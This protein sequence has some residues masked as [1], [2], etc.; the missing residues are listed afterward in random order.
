MQSQLKILRE[1]IQPKAM[2]PDTTPSLRDA[3]SKPQRTIDSYYITPSLRTL[4]KE[5]LDAAIHRKGQGYWYRAA[6]GDGKTHFIASM[7][8]LLTEKA[9][10]VWNALHDDELR[11]DYQAPLSGLK[12]FPVTFSLLGTGEADA[13]DSLMRRFEKEIRDSLPPELRDQVSVLSEELA[14]EW[15]ENEAGDLIKKAIADHFT[16]THGMPPDEFRAKEGARK[17]GAE[18][19]SVAKDQGVIIDV[20]GAFRERFAH[21]YDRITKLGGYDGLLFVVDEFRSWQ[22]RHEGKPSYEEGVQVLE[23]LAYYLPVEE[24]LNII[25]VI[26]S[27]G[28][29]PQKLM[30]AS[31]GDRFIVRELLSGK[32]QTD[33]G[34]IVCFRVRDVL[35]GREIEIEEYYKHC[36]DKF[37]F[38]RQTPKDYFRAIFAF[39]PRCFDILRRVTQSYDRYG[40]PSTRSGIHIA[41]E[42]LTSDSLLDGRRLVVL[43]DLLGSRTLETGLRAE[44]F[45]ASFQSYRDTLETLETLPMEDEERD[46]SRR[47]IGTL[48]LWS[49]VNADIAKGLTLNELAE[50]T[51][52]SL[53]GVTPADAVLDLV[54]RLKS[55]IPQVKYDRDKGARFEVAESTG[56]KPE[57]AFGTFKKK[58]KGNRD[59]QDRAWRDS[60][61]WDFKSLEG[62]GSE[63]G[64]DGGFFDGYGT[65]DAKGELSLPNTTVVQATPDALKVQ[66]GGDVVVTDR[67]QATL[68]ESWSNRPETHFRIVYLTSSA[69]IDRSDL[70]DP[71]SAVCS[72]AALSDETRENLAEF[73]ACEAM[74]EHYNDKDYPGEGSLR[75]WA[76]TRR[77]G[78]RVAILKNQIEEFRRGTITTQKELGLPANQFFMTPQKSRGRREEAIASQLLEKAYDRPRF[79]P[80]D[81]KKDFTDADSKKV[82]HGLFAKTPTNADQNARDNFAPGLGLVAKN[83][84]AEFAPQPDSAV[85]YIAER[86]RSASDL[87][88]SELVKELCMP[89]YGMTEDMVRLMALCAVRS[90][91]P[92][93]V[94]ADLNP[95]G[96]FKLTDGREPPNKRL[97]SRLISQTEWSTK[98]EKAFLGA[99]LKLSDEKPFNDVL[100]YALVVDPSLTTANTPDE[101]IARNSEL[102]LALNTLAGD[103]PNTRDTLKKLSGVLGGSL[104]AQTTEVFQRLA[105]IAATG[106]YQEFH[107]V[108][109]ENYTTP[110][111]FQAATDLYQRAKR[112]NARYPDLQSAKT[113]LENLA[114]LG[115]VNLEHD[116]RSLSD[117]MGFESLW[118]NEQLLKVCIEQFGRFKDKYSLAYRKGHRA[119]HEVLEKLHATLAGLDDKL[120][121]LDRLNSLELG[122]PMGQRLC[123]DV[124]NL[125]DRVRPC[126]LKDTCRVDD[127]PKCNVCHWDGQTLP[128]QADADDLVRRVNDANAEL[129]K[130]VAQGAIRKILENANQEGVRTLLDMITASRIEDLAKVLTPEMVAKLKEILAAANIEHRDLPLIPLLEDFTALEEE[131]MD[132]FL[133]RL[134][135]RLL[136]AFDKA[137][138]ETEGRKRIRFFLK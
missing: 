111:Q 101:E 7:T 133:K 73:V 119:Y 110:E 59:A 118:K 60:L 75:D 120:A 84:L 56:K 21:I 105:T 138:Q 39:Q 113:Y 64:F 14:V 41:W 90:A 32:D 10:E 106:D 76:K 50:G 91:N 85:M 4:L 108:V 27:Q 34:Q 9:P 55:D 78:A 107:S 126:A 81:L 117:G 100:P 23:T 136:A 109:R 15:Y 26:A 125:R 67:W 69:A 19:L 36:R 74:L 70:Q 68:G 98:L 127:R 1:I 20:K 35:A 83:N 86:V 122:A 8:V 99:R 129:C 104:D 88:V 51:M 6:Y 103:V 11:R 102:M 57:Q 30:G 29:C 44:Q 24:N 80:K 17:L 13:G 65:R 66:Y 31:Q 71:R 97:T 95:G 42:T 3:L 49:V 28:D 5:I 89:P 96:N 114:Q 112:F 58:A 54:T 135:T 92:P 2:E 47:I 121:V 131:H 46:S 128:P 137:K 134:R 82:F 43:S 116:A 12:L 40:L 18:L 45:R 123:Q 130:R 33:Y 124:G 48:Y 115:D 79:T 132:D 63:E 93:I 94:L 53:E 38:L 52:T 22:D 61:F 87:A 77:R 37:S 16:A 62:A 72:P 25:T